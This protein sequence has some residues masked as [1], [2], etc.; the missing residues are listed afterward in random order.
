MKLSIQE[1]VKSAQQA[2]VR[3]KMMILSV[4][5]L[6]KGCELIQTSANL[7]NL[8]EAPC[9]YGVSLLLPMM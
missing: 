5:V 8:V 2:T 9:T 1:Q 6:E 4:K 7:H 3:G